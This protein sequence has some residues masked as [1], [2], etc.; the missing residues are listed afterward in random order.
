MS[1]IRLCKNCSFVDFS[2]C[3]IKLSDFPPLPDIASVFHA[4]KWPDMLVRPFLSA[5]HRRSPCRHPLRLKEYKAI[6]NIRMT[7][8][9]EG[10]SKKFL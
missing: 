7:C 10:A 8:D 3:Q 4:R 2:S 9:Q 6:T 5:V 1:R